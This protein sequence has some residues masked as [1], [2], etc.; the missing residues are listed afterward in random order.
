[1]FVKVYFSRNALHEDVYVKV[2]ISRNVQRWPSMVWERQSGLYRKFIKIFKVS[3][4]LKLNTS[5]YFTIST[6]ELSQSMIRYS[7]HRH[8][9]HDGHDGHDGI[10]GHDGHGGHGGYVGHGGCL[11]EN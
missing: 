6:R 11:I 9:G 4:S 3:L 8:V 10:A 7:I 1:M 2:Y 5:S